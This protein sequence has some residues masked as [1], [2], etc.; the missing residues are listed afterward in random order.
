MSILT[1]IGATLAPKILDIVKIRAENK[2][3]DKQAE[4]E[5]NKL[6]IE[7]KKVGLEFT[8]QPLI[9]YTFPVLA[10]IFTAGLGL[11]LLFSVL[12]I[13]FEKEFS[14]YQI[15]KEHFDLM[16]IYLAGFFGNKAVKSW[17]E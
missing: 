1:T 15:E 7:E 8:K 17:K 12:P 5:I 11:N 4:I 3:D 6:L 16:K 2:I 10:W 9:Y 14:L 13:F